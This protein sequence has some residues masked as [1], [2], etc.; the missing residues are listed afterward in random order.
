M[1][2][3]ADFYLINRKDTVT[4]EDV[5]SSLHSRELRHQASGTSE[6]Q[7]VGFSATT[8]D[9]DDSSS[10]RDV[11]L[12]VV[13]YKGTPLVWIMDSGCSFH[14]IPS[15]D[16]FVTYKEFNGR[17]VFMGNDSP[18]NVIGII[19]IRIRMHD[20]V[21]TTLT[22]VSHVLDLKKNLISLGVLDLKGLKYMSENDVLRFSKGTLVVMTAIKDYSK[23]HVSRFLSYYHVSEGKLDSRGEKGIFMGYDDAVKGYRICRFGFE[24]YVA[25]A[26]Q[27]AEEAESLE[28]ATYREAITSKVRDMW[29]AAIAHHDLELEKLNIKTA[30][31]YGDLEEEIYMSQ[32]EGFVVQSKEDYV[33]KLQKSLYGLKQ[34]SRQWYKRF[35]SFMKS[36]TEKIISRFGTSLAKSV[37]T[38]SLA[39]FCLSTTYSPQSEA[40]IEYMSRIPYANDVGSLMYVMVFTRPDIA[41]AMSV[42][43]RYMA[44]LEKEH[45]NAMKR[46]FCYL[47][48]T[49]DVDLIY[50]GEREYLIVGY[51]YSDYAVNLDAK[52]SLTFYVFTI[53]NS[54]VSW[55]A[56]LQPSVALSTIEA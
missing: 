48:R 4:L 35:D 16:W 51:S 15:R 36:Y 2:D 46:I 10:E 19:T 55:K 13:D 33:C 26:L 9:M 20:G 23:L 12:S 24:D 27:V 42:V 25:Y 37:N 17:H 38:H 39:N 50:G 40:E 18:C 1:P 52:R 29:I 8:Q 44:H 7:P 22:D 11:V 31:L 49:F 21:V 56:T 34:S 3:L 53:G 5:R 6:S 45:W 54:V 32:P 28:P 43:S 47:K 14:M 41:H 30:F